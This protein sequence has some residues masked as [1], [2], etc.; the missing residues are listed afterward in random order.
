MWNDAY[1][2]IERPN[3]VKA[4][5]PED[6]APQSKFH[7]SNEILTVNKPTVSDFRTFFISIP[8]IPF[9]YLLRTVHL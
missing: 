1:T 3:A 9:S 7:V 2:L 4:I 5:L 8:S 6:P